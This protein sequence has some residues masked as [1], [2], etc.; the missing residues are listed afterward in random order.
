MSLAGAVEGSYRTGEKGPV[1]VILTKCYRDA[2]SVESPGVFS[3]F[4][5]KK[6]RTGQIQSCVSSP[7]TWKVE[8]KAK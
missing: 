2:S 5:L 6:C 4:R 8:M 7:S 3:D 1:N